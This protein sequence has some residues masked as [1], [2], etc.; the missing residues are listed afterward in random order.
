MLLINLLLEL[1]VLEDLRLVLNI[2]KLQLQFFALLLLVE[3][4]LEEYAPVLLLSADL[5]AQFAVSFNQLPIL[6]V[7]FL[8][9]LG[10][11]LQMIIQLLLS[12]LKIS[13]TIPFYI[14]LTYFSPFLAFSSLIS[15]L[16]SSSLAS[17]TSQISDL[18]ISRDWAV[19]FWMRTRVDISRS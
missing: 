12:L 16:I 6:K 3:E 15:P 14:V 8:C 4:L 19:V 13:L 1:L 2:P 5:D 7:N 10:H 11:S 9:D 18:W 17:S